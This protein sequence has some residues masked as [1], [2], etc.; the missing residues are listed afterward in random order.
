MAA[1]LT[2]RCSEKETL[3]EAAG[4]T[5][6]VDR[7]SGVIKK[8]MMMEI[9]AAAPV[10]SMRDFLLFQRNNMSAFRCSVRF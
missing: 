8:E 9:T 5:I 4:K 10:N 3:L 7:K 1:A 2:F 6:A